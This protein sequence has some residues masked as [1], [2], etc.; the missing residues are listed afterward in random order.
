MTR[1]WLVIIGVAAGI[2]ALSLASAYDSPPA[3]YSV[4]TQSAPSP[5]AVATAEPSGNAVATAK[6]S[7][8]PPSAA[9]I[10][11]PTTP[12][13]KPSAS[14]AE[15]QPTPIG[16]PSRI[17][18]PSAS[19]DKPLQSGGLNSKGIVSPPPA[20]VMWLDDKTY[21]NV[22]P[23]QLGTSIIAG[24]VVADGKPDVF[25]ELGEVSQGDEVRLI[26][27]D[28]AELELAVISA[29]VIRKDVLVHDPR[30]WAPQSSE[31]RVAIITCSDK[32]GYREDRH[33][34]AN[35][36]VIAVPVER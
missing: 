23:G 35:Y 17:I 33:R 15:K 6:P 14:T 3:D 10:P 19:V 5:M 25:S 21:G 36:V 29:E 4:M 24:H 2:L 16:V 7:P 27:P 32:Q 26:Y 31:N 11:E 9:P 20:T 34:V 12:E 30:L 28:G 1:R 22:A 18:I 8:V 13:A